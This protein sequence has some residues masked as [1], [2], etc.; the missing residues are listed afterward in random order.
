MIKII[1]ELH[2]GFPDSEDEL[3]EIY[4]TAIIEMPIVN[5]ER[6]SNPVSWWQVKP[7]FHAYFFPK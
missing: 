7:V 4:L 2:E 1:L 3:F 5:L 6:I